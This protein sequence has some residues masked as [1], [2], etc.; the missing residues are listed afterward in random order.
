MLPWVRS[1]LTRSVLTHL[2]DQKIRDVI[3]QGARALVEGGE[4]TAIVPRAEGHGRYRERGFV[5]A[6]ARANRIES[7]PSFHPPV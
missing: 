4:P 2:L 6:A 3:V 1:Q 7:S 5:F